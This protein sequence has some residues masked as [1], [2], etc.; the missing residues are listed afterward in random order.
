MLTRHEYAVRDPRV[1]GHD[2]ADSGFIVQ[3]PD[4]FL[5]AAL[6]HLDDGTF[7]PT[8]LIGTTDAYR[9]TVAVHDLAHLSIRQHDGRRAIIRMQEAMPIAMTAD[10]TDNEW[11]ALAQA[12]FLTPIAQQLTSVE[13]RL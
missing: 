11:Q 1:V 2:E 4:D 3:T 7:G 9:Y 6:Q 5:R 8:A 12:I 10:R 13:R